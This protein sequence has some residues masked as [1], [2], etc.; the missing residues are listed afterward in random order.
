MV[1]LPLEEVALRCRSILVRIPK[2]L[3]E[4]FEGMPSPPPLKHVQ[5]AIDLLNQ[6]SALNEQ[7]DL[8]TIGKFLC[9][10]PVDVRLGKLLLYSIILN[11]LE[12]ILTICAV[13]SL[14]KSPFLDNSIGVQ[15]TKA[16]FR[17][18]KVYYE[19]CL[20]LL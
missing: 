11:C 4:I 7:E 1:R 13:L 10:L 20:I 12:P 19:K 15:S 8:T 18:G 16:R 6:V 3:T 14:G 17:H 2:S 9:H 5:Q